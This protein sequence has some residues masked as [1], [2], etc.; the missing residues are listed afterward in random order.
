MKAKIEEKQQ[1]DLLLSFKPG[2]FGGLDDIFKTQ[3]AATP[4]SQEISPFYNK[5]LKLMNDR[6]AAVK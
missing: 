4:A 6:F 2:G 5:Y 1:N 3:E